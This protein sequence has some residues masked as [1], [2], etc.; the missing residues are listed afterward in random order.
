MPILCRLRSDVAGQL[1]LRRASH[2]DS[3]RVLSDT[4]N[5]PFGFTDQVIVNS[6]FYCFF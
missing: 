2:H 3:R 5:L 4:K 6:N 1:R